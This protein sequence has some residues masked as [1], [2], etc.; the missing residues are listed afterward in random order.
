M[1]DVYYVAVNAFYIKD[2]HNRGISYYSSNDS[3]RVLKDNFGVKKT[4][5]GLN[6]IFGYQEAINKK[7]LFDIYCG[8]GIRFRYVDN[9]SKEFV[10]GRDKLLTAI[11]I[12]V[13]AI[14]SKTEARGGFSVAPNLSFGIRGCYRL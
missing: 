6:F 4:V 9:V 11:D 14:T 7:F 3:S 10:Y 2:V 12:N 1:S 13:H 8:P 5:W